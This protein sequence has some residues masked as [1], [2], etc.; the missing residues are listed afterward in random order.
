MLRSGARPG[1]FTSHR[2]M[3]S[4]SVP[5]GTAHEDEDLD[6]IQKKFFT[7]QEVAEA[8][9]LAKREIHE[10]KLRKLRRAGRKSKVQ[11]P[12]VSCEESTVL[13]QPCRGSG[14]GEPRAHIVVAQ[15]SSSSSFA[16]KRNCCR[17]AGAPSESY[18]ASRQTS[19]YGK[20]S[21]C[22]CTRPFWS[23]T[24]DVEPTRSE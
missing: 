9:R 15:V 11:H 14:P 13:A 12:L 22:S 24:H 7:R 23:V 10:L 16:E 19:P 2:R 20:Y 6:V 21:T 4:T 3:R 8:E 17:C 18:L 5:K 1:G